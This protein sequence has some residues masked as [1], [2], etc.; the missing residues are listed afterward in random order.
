MKTQ[1]FDSIFDLYA[2]CLQ[3]TA[4]GHDIRAYEDPSCLMLGWQDCT[5]Q[6]RAEASL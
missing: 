6:E 2:E 4:D 5:T 3:R 1:R